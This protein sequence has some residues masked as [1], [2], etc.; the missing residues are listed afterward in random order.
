[1]ARRCLVAVLSVVLMLALT[2]GVAAQEPVY[3]TVAWG[4][5]LSWIAHLYGV[6]VRDLVEANDLPNSNLIYAGQR[7]LIP[8]PAQEYI[9]HVVTTGE[10]LLTISAK[11]GV[12]IWE[13]AK[14]SQLANINLI[15]VGQR[16]RIPVEVL[17]ELAGAEDVQEDIII[18]SPQDEGQVGTSVTVTGWGSGYDNKLAVDVLDEFGFIV[19]Q[20]FVTVDA[21]SGEY[22]PFAGIVELD[23]A[24]AASVGRVQVYSIS[25]SDGAI[26]HLASVKVSAGEA[27]TA[28][29][30][31]A[32]APVVQEAII[33][34]SPAP[35]IDVSSPITV[36]GWGSGFGNLLGVDVLD[37]VGT[38]IGQGY[39]IVDAEFG[40]YGPFEGRIGFTTP[41]SA[42][43]GRIQV[44]SISPK[45]GAIEHLSSVLV[46]LLP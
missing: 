28:P 42:Q 20:G 35:R 19:G 7:L 32:M 15:Y 8:G 16:L 44:Y 26:E 40:E 18:A 45:D 37:E 31:E 41:A 46:N 1:M 22:G 43:I 11:Y 24:G 12:S 33:I 14:H 2:L 6:T 34:A 10:S 3:H 23:Q 17:P 25:P 29:L 38:V 30:P 4:Q 13:I 5:S 21:E 9:E 36:T 27:E 39:A